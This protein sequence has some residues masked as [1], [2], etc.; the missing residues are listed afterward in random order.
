MLRLNACSAGYGDTTVFADVTLTVG[1]SQLI[2]VV[3]RSGCGKTTLV[4]VA[5]GLIQPR[6]GAVTLHGEPLCAGDLRIGLV[7][8]HYGL[9]PWFTAGR[10]V[11]IGLELRRIGREERRAR[12]AA[13]LSE[14][15]LAE[16]ARRYPAELSGGE[17]QR[18]ALARTTALGPEV[19]LLDEPFSSLDA[20]T[21]EALQEELLRLQDLHARATLMVTHSLEEAVFLADRIGVMYGRPAAL[22]VLDNPWGRPR[23]ERSHAARAEADFTAAVAA[24]R[25]RFEE[26]T[27]GA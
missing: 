27:R 2:A 8:Q 5:A 9:F 12:A 16:A 3:G 21:R 11:E 20:F 25:R 1:P 13:A 24:L 4:H 18:V 15:G 7:Q 19:L 22:S 23:G 26:R 6:A 14:L 10:N 17:Q